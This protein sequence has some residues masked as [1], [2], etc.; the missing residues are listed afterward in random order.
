MG[1]DE[2]K[3]LINRCIAKLMKS[4]DGHISPLIEREIKHHLRW[5]EDDIRLQ[6]NNIRDNK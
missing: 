5:L 1:N 2:A 3:K 4:L 6:F